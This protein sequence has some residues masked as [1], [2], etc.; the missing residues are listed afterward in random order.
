MNH[1]MYTCIYILSNMNSTSNYTKLVPYE[2]TLS[3]ELFQALLSTPVSDT[4][5]TFV[6]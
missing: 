6:H 5:I 4:V 1:I 2:Y 3:P